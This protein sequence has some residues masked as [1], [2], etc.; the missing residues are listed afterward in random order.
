M[1]DYDTIIQYENENSSLDFKAIQYKKEL[2]EEFIKDVVSMANADVVD[3]RH[4]II[5]V[6]LESNGERTLIGIKDTFTD[7]STYQQ[8][9]TEN[10]EPTIDID[11]S[12]YT[13]EN[14]IFGIFRIANCENKPYVL[15]KDYGKNLK[16]GDSFIRK[17]THKTRMDRRDF[18]KIYES[19]SS[20]KISETDIEIYFSEGNSHEIT[21]SPAQDI[22]LASE[23][24]TKEILE[25]LENREK[26]TEVDRNP[27]YPASSLGQILSTMENLRKIS[28]YQYLEPKS[29]A[30]KTTAELEECLKNVKKD[31][32][33][34]DYY[35]FF[36]YYSVEINFQVLNNGKKYIED[37]SI[38]VE[39]PVLDGLFVADRHI[40]RPIYPLESTLMRPITG[41]SPLN[42]VKYPYVERKDTIIE[43]SQSLGDVKHH[44]PL[45]AFEEPLKVVFLEKL[46]DQTVEIKVK[47][48]G[49]DL[50]EPIIK[51]LRINVSNPN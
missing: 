38:F 23:K 12:P 7:P 2:F 35:E 51:I 5:G 8:L 36:K 6:K 26:T 34:A 3:C 20:T 39:I 46:I 18:D 1:V 10:V 31:Y 11:Y 44:I 45:T 14:K 37:A 21:V 30:N 19:K 40:E 24:A 9:I 25:E 48:Y 42:R 16:K 27:L 22:V 17:G 41:I 32:F 47:I 50:P 43:V 4:I 15:K 49:R 13:F 28:S 33:Q 29:Y